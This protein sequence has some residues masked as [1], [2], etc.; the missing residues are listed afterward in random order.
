MDKYL[1]SDYVNNTEKTVKNS[2]IS[3]VAQIISLILQFIN[4][5]IFIIF[6]DI[7][8]LGYQSLFGNIF[9]LLSVAE[10]GIGNIISFHLYKEI[11]NK[12]TDEI[13]KLMYLYKWI[14]RIV[15]FV[16]LIG[17]IICS[18]FVPYIVKDSS[19]E[20]SYLY[21]IYFV[22][23]ISVLLGYFL[24]YRRTI[25]IATQQEYKCVQLELFTNIIIQII[26]LST[27]AIFKNYILYLCFQLS[28]SILSNLWIYLKTNKEFPFLKKKYKVSKDEIKKRNMFD[29]IKNYFFHQICYLIYSGTDNIVISTING[30]RSVALYGNYTLIQ[31]GVMN[32]L[33]YKLLNPI[34]ATIGNIL[35]SE[36][37]KKE[38]WEQFNVLDTF[39]FFFAS[40]IGLGFFVFYQP[41]IEIWL[42]EEYLL[43]ESFVIIFSITIYLGAAWEIICKY[44]FLFGDYKQDRFFMLLSAILNITIS[45]PGAMMFGVTGVQFGTLIAFLPIGIG[46]IRFVVKNYFGQSVAKYLIKHLGLLILMLIEGGVA[47]VL[48]KKADITFGGIL[49]RVIMW[50]V[51]PLI[52]NTI[53]F[54]R[55]KYFK[56]MIQYLKKILGILV[57]K[58]RK[59][60]TKNDFSNMK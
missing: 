13:G 1:G 45:I 53:V 35:Y 7:E 5:K 8:Y 18:I 23:L 48:L 57:R 60:N 39:G 25:Y 17:G 16:V 30:I 26:Q 52:M 59:Q 42:G 46:R 54:C 29:D 21:I 12:N 22:Q 2:L 38:L 43:S 11:V 3:V 24:S 10:L 19:E 6:L 15:A 44:R 33:F 4:R 51:I 41:A 32:V 9:S 14:Y 58:V 28:T 49:Y 56:Q 36:R 47:Y 37:E 55:N 50:L 20:L 31:K 34:Q 27:L 40:Y